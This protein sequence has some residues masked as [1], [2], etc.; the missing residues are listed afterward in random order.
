V[1]H[2]STSLRHAA[3]KAPVDDLFRSRHADNRNLDPLLTS[4]VLQLLKMTV[5]GTKV[6][7]LA[8]RYDGTARYKATSTNGASGTY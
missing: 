1:D 3:L 8:Q 7:I 2:N 4:R 6:L 5:P